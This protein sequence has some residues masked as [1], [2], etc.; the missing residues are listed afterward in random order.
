MVLTRRIRININLSQN[1]EGRCRSRRVSWRL[2]LWKRRRPMLP[3]VLVRKLLSISRSLNL[4]HKLNLN[5]YLCLSKNRR[6]RSRKTK[7]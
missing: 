7:L 5:L 2:R 3:Q 4:N 1:Y 6:K